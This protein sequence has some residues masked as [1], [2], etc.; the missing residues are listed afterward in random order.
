MTCAASRPMRLR[1]TGYVDGQKQAWISLLFLFFIDRTDSISSLNAAGSA[2]PA[3]CKRLGLPPA[4]EKTSQ[5]MFCSA[6]CT[7]RGQGRT[8]ALRGGSG[9][10]FESRA[11][12]GGAMSISLPTSFEDISVIR[13][14]PDNQEVFVDRL[15]EDSIIVEV[16]ESVDMKAKPGSLQEMAAQE[17]VESWD[18]DK[19]NRERV[20]E[21][22]A[23]A[24][25]IFMDIANCSNSTESN[26]MSIR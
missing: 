12:Y 19:L 25:H 10:N 11:L 18:I 8:L 21:A 16:L 7:G 22:R 3:C 24:E 20:D 2:V 4:W 14:V 9:L 5:G 26:I 23:A 1:A 6:L 13:L 17:D 15:S